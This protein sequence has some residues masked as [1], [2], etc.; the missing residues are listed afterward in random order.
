[1][2]TAAGPLV[3]ANPETAGCSTGSSTS[4]EAPDCVLR[5]SQGGVLSDS[6]QVGSAVALLGPDPAVLTP[7]AADS[8]LQV[9]RLS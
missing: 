4:T 1:V 3:L 8:F 5:I 9:D 2:D 7:N 6:T